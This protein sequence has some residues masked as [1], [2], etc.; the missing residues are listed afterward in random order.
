MRSDTES[1]SWLR[2]AE[3]RSFRDA[4]K[5]SQAEIQAPDNFTAK[6]VAGCIHD[7]GDGGGGGSVGN[8]VSVCE[9]SLELH[10][11]GGGN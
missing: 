6:V 10:S 1:C 5:L 11:W 7:Q 9:R 4:K 2:W 3:V 8:A